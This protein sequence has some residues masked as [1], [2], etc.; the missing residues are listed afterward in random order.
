MPRATVHRASLPQARRAD[1]MNPKMC[2][3]LIVDNASRAGSE[4]IVEQSQ[5]CYKSSSA[6]SQRRAPRVATDA[7][8]E[9]VDD[10][11]QAR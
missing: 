10:V 2:K 6:P 5:R 7:P 11:G 1:G 4:R 9:R 3:F 8:D